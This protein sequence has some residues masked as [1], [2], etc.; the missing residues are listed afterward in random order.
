[1]TWIALLWLASST[2]MVGL[3]CRSPLMEHW[4]DDMLRRTPR[5]GQTV[6]TEKMRAYI[7]RRLAEGATQATIAVEMKISQST[8]SKVKQ[9]VR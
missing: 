7:L 2:V 5:V 1:M 8:V 4:R 6:L 3:V 9:G